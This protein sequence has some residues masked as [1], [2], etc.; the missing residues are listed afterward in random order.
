M[1]KGLEISH[2]V[3]DQWGVGYTLVFL[4]YCDLYQGDYEGAKDY[5]NQ[6]LE[7]TRK[8]GMR[9]GEAIVHGKLMEVFWCLGDYKSAESFRI[10]HADMMGM[11][12]SK[13]AEARNLIIMSMLKL[14]MGDLITALEYSRKT[15]DLIQ[16]YKNHELRLNALISHG[17][18]FAASGEYEEAEKG[19][20]EAVILGM[21]TNRPR[22]TMEALAGWAQASVA[23]GNLKLAFSQV[24][25]ILTFLET[26]RP[27]TGNPLDGTMEPFRIYL[28]C[29]QVLK[30]N[31]DPRADAI[32][33]EAYN[34]LQTR[35][36]NISDEHL[37]D[38]FLNNV[39]ANRE[40]VGE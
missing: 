11:R 39:A 13:Y 4:G 22:Q 21:K 28:T 25:K 34:L 35:A 40:I 5:F 23:S 16:G 30:A 14:H 1:Y 24:E 26:E 18:I 37:R 3:E 32:L 33:T 10:K 31:K 36:A 38:C 15:L 9:F 29:Y 2:E 17:H 12:E 7:I 6:A 19:F 8:T 20:Q 27:S